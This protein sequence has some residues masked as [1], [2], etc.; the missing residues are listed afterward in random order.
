MKAKSNER[1]KKKTKKKGVKIMRYI[2]RWRGRKIG[3]KNINV[4]RKEGKE[5]KK[6]ARR[7]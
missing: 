6:K 4:K 5:W 1:L 2:E 7:N 3:K